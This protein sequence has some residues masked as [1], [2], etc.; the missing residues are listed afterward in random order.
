MTTVDH[1]FLGLCLRIGR[2]LVP[3]ER[4]NQA[5]EEGPLV[6]QMDSSG[7]RRK[8]VRR[9]RGHPQA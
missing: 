9:E 1:Y 4:L 2:F 6:L 3:Q 5:I 8:Q 7:R